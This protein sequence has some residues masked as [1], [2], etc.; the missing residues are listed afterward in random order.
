[1]EVAEHLP[2]SC[3]RRFVQLLTALSPLVVFTAAT[4]GQGGV[5]HVNEQ[6]HEYWIDL[7]QSQGFQFDHRL[8]VEWRGQWE[9]A[10]V[11]S[12]YHRNLMIFRQAH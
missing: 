3:A 7:F 6:P 9:A 1:M 8:S 11:A 12:F 4:P 2:K 10:G 5:D